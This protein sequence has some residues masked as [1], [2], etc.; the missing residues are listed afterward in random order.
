MPVGAHA[1]GGA[2]ALMVSQFSIHL[3]VEKHRRNSPLSPARSGLA[4]PN[5]DHRL[6]S[7]GIAVHGFGDHRLVG[8][9]LLA[10]EDAD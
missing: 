10:K 5:R 9:L 6:V 2:I 3:L 1:D 7:A 8:D 4:F